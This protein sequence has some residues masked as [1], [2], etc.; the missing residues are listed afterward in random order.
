MSEPILGICRFSYLGR[1]DWGAYK[2]T[3]LD[4]PEQEAARQRVAS[5]LYRPDR[6]EL[7][8]QSFETLT[9]PSIAAQTDRDFDFL[10]LTSPELPAPWRARLQLLC[11]SV[12]RVR[13]LVSDATDVGRAL[14][15]VLDTAGPLLQFRLDD[16]D[17]LTVHYIAH[18]RRAAAAMR[19]H[20]HFAF[21]LPRALL[22]TQYGAGAQRYEVMKP[23][24]GAGVA[25]RLPD[26]KPIFAYGHYALARRFPSL[27][28]PT[29]HGSL[30]TKTAGHDSKE[31]RSGSGID[32]I[33]DARFASVLQREFPFLDQPTRRRL[34]A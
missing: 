9:L 2:G 29:V 21:S 32:D 27:S 18:L 10:V 17:C 33:A 26:R 8:F 6:L 15:P 3:A 12:P 14:E 23:F 7:R 13:L 16:D 22:V 5:E 1:G 28:D 20:P 19:D 30:Q 34:S 4:S 24:H 31:V 11:D 25:A